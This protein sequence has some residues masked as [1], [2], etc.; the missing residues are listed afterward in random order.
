M[1]PQ[2]PPL[3]PFNG[4][5]IPAL[6]AL[7]ARLRPDH[8]FI[9]WEPFTGASETWT[10]ARFHHDVR[11]IAAGLAKRGVRSGESVLLHFDN[12]PETVLAWYAC[13]HIGAVA[14]TTNARSSADEL[15]YFATHSRAVAA[16]TQPCFAEL[17]NGASRDFRF[18]AVTAHD[19]GAPPAPGFAPGR[20]ERFEAL[21]GDA[22][23]AP[24]RAPD[25]AHPVGVQY[26]SGT[27]SRP[28]GVLWTHANALWGA[29]INAAAR[30]SARG[31][32]ASRSPAALPHQ[33]AGLF[34][35]GDAMGRRHGGAHA[36]I[37][38]QPLLAAVAETSLHLDV[39]HS[40]LREGA[41]ERG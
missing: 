28:K 24:L 26:T 17:V 9:I 5:D 16:I 14:V 8:P 12:C 19:N 34:G 25:P 31:R 36:A 10:Y 37:L 3:H 41:D 2:T 27:T 33:C 39:G 21:Y 18:I 22:A 6:V 15:A 32:R 11:R 38:V 7:R 29:R 23:D 13:A 20:T 35:A 40:V 1:I 30:G 4:F